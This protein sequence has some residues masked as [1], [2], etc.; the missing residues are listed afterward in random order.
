[1]KRYPAL[2]AAVLLLPALAGTT[3]LAAERDRRALPTS[4][5]EFGE[6][7]G[8]EGQEQMLGAAVAKAIREASHIFR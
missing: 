1:M 5:A 8:F 4:A 2:L 6:Y 3:A 7:S